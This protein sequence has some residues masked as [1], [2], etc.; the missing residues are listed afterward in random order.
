MMEVGDLVI[1]DTNSH[2][3]N[4]I[5]DIIGVPFNEVGVVTAAEC[6]VCSIIFPS[7]GGEV[8]NFMQEDLKIISEAK[9]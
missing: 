7:M 9:K 3:V 4:G 2:F 8:K 5:A 1:L 6:G